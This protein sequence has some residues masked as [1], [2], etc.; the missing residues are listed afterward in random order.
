MNAPSN[1]FVDHING[2]GLDNRRA[3]LRLATA[4]QNNWNSKYGM[5]I[6][7]S[8]YKGVQW[9]KH[10][11]KWVAAISIDGQKKCLG[12]YS[13]EKEAARAFDKAAKE[14]RGQ[15]AVLNFADS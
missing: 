15:F 5:G 7:T 1:R 13:N 11:K 12:Y 10:R 9:H 2:D 8:R 6:G 3:N 14:R 4:A